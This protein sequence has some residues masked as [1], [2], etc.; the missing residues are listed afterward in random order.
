[1]ACCK[2]PC[3]E[4][5]QGYCNCLCSRVRDKVHPVS[6]TALHAR[7]LAPH[8]H[9]CCALSIACSAQAFVDFEAPDEAAR[10]IKEKDHKVF[11]DKFGD[12]YVRLIQVWSTGKLLVGFPCSARHFFC[13]RLQ[14]HT[15]PKRFGLCLNH[16]LLP[17]GLEMECPVCSPKAFFHH[18]Q[19]LMLDLLHLNE[20]K[21]LSTIEAVH[22]LPMPNFHPD[23]YDSYRHSCLCIA[24]QVSRKEMQAT[25]A[26]R[27][28]GEGILKI[29]GIPFKVSLRTDRRHKSGQHRIGK[30]FTEATRGTGSIA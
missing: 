13:E 7:N 6:S 5:K 15:G 17:W 1:M 19:A 24:S 3:K 2:G 26:L 18:S 16:Q 4:G 22:A 12:R 11:S 28:G 25:L 14:V 8:A 10:A 21:S 27:F 30:R 29:K 23:L 20:C 9:S